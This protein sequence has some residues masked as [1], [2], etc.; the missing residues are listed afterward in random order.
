MSERDSAA[1]NIQLVAVKVKFAIAGQNLS[2]KSLIQLHQI[3]VGDSETVFL[4]HLFHGRD[5]ANSH[6]PGINPG[7]GDRDN[8]R[9]G[10]QIVLLYEGLAGKNQGSRSVGDSGGISRGDGTIM[11]E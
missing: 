6:D 5:R 11:G 7:G 3:E 10:I 4:L 2:G 1:V 8:S 9:Q